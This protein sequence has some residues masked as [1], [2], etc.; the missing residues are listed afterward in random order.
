MTESLRLLRVESSL[1][2]SD[3]GSGTGAPM[4][5]R[6]PARTHACTGNRG[7]IW[8]LHSRKQC[9]VACSENYLYTCDHT[10]PHLG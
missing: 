9:S 7:K 4:A 2:V 1:K 3:P 6:M 5:A 8:Q 10:P